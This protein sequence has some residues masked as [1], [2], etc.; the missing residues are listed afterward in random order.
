[1][2]IIKDFQNEIIPDI[3]EIDHRVVYNPL[4][5][6]E[7]K[8]DPNYKPFDNSKGKKKGTKNRIQV[9]YTIQDAYEH[10]KNTVEKDLQLDKKTYIKLIKDFFK[11]VSEKIL[12]ES[13]E[14]VM[15][16]KLGLIRIRK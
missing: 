11:S 7:K 1:M 2:N 8:K 14:I 9:D 4:P 3:P 10:Y 16:C 12:L 15:H 13:E 6:E 5:F